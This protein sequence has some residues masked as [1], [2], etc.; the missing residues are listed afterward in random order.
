MGEVHYEV[1]M[2]RV[3]HTARISNVDNVMFVNKIREM[4]NFELHKGIEH[5]SAESEGLRFDFSWRIRIFFF[6]TRSWQDEKHLSPLKRP[7]PSNF[8]LKEQLIIKK[9]LDVFHSVS[10]GLARTLYYAHIINKV[11]F[12]L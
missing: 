6:V 9:K 8:F 2:T 3:L 5:R 11:F 12:S 1:H 10:Q 7:L 4:V